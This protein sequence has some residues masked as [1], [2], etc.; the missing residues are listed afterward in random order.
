MAGKPSTKG[1]YGTYETKT[2]TYTG[3]QTPEQTWNALT[4]NVN[5]ILIDVRTD[6]EINFVGE[7]D[8][9]SLRKDPLHIQWVAFPHGEKNKNFLP[10]LIDKVP[11]KNTPLYFFCRSG[12]R[13]QY[14][15][16]LASQAG[17]KNSYNVLEGFEGD[18]NNEDHRG[19]I[20]GWK[21]AGLPWLQD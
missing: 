13:S 10:E 11:D 19:S 8:L 1:E 21:V 9:S 3:D 15:A 5:S 14:A 16:S 20:G 17:Y 2:C 4:E 6:A 12:V 18:T 7:P